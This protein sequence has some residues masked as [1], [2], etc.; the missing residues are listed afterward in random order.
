MFTGRG[1]IQTAITCER[2]RRLP[3]AHADHNSQP[4]RVQLVSL[5]PSRIPLLGYNLGSQLLR[6]TFWLAHQGRDSKPTAWDPARHRLPQRAA[7]EQPR[8]CDMVTFYV[9]PLQAGSGTDPSDVVMAL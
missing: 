6:V 3:Q 5:T 1:A 9:R 2:G 8:L 7:V 4:T